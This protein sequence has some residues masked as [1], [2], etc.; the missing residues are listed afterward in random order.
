MDEWNGVCSQETE[1][2]LCVEVGFG[3]VL[4]LRLY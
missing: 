1:C 2:A 3:I 4:G